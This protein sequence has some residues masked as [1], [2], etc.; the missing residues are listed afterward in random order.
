[1][2]K[3]LLTGS[4]PP[5]NLSQLDLS[6]PNWDI[7]LT[8]WNSN[9]HHSS[10]IFSYYQHPQFGLSWLIT[11]SLSSGSFSMTRS[12]ITRQRNTI[13]DSFGLLGLSLINP[14]DDRVILTEGVSDFFTA[15]LLCP[16]S[17]VLGVTTLGGSSLAKLLLLN[18]FNKF[19]ICSDNDSNTSKNTGLNNSFNWKSFLQSYNK[20]VQVFLPLYPH[21]DI[22]DNFIFNLKL[23]SHE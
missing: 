7:L 23:Y 17:N 20:T 12:L 22:S 15:K 11:E 10:V 18:L 2:L 9:F 8:L 3:D 14:K 16:N 1:M 5:L 13:S 21:K 6:K 19:I 4:L